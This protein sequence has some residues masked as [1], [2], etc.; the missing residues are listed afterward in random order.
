YGVVRSHKDNLVIID[1][2]IVRGTTL[3]NSILRILDRLKPK[4]IIIVSSAPHFPAI[5]FAGLASHRT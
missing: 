2:S 4:K 3:R 1:D 5:D